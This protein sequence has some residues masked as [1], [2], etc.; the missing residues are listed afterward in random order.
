MAIVNSSTWSTRSLN[1]FNTYYPTPTQISPTWTSFLFDNSIQ[2]QGIYEFDIRFQETGKQV[3]NTGADD[4]AQF[5]IDGEYLG[6]FGASNNSK[7][8]TTTKYYDA[9]SVHRITIVR[10]DSGIKPTA[11]AA[12]WY[13]SIYDFVDVDDFSAAPPILYNTKTTILAWTVN[14]ARK[15]E[16]NQNIGDVTGLT[17]KSINT[18]LQSI[19]GTISPASKIY[20]LTAYGNAPSDILT[21]TVEVFAYNDTTPNKIDIPHFY[22]R[23]PNETITYTLPTITGIDAPITVS[24]NGS[25]LFAANG[26]S[27]FT[28]NITVNNNAVVQIRFVSLG[29][30]QD[31]QTLDNTIEYYV[32]IG[33][34]RKY[35]TVTTRA[36]ND[37][38]IF[39][40]GDIKNSVPYPVPP[41]NDENPPQ[42]LV[43]PDTVEPT[44]A[45]WEVELQYPNNVTLQSGVEIKTTYNDNTEIRVKPFGGSWGSWV[46]TEYLYDELI[47]TIPRILEGMNLSSLT[48]RDNGTISNSQPK[49]I[50][51]RSS[52]TLTA[53]NIVE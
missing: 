2:D 8:I 17:Q 38:E 31:P 26:V 45:Q 53:K 24:S 32:N 39:D 9:L 29:F 27:A 5:Y 40:F 6:Q 3:F 19:V 52:G 16:I 33:S 35:F 7:L 25:V 4:Y 14:N 20:T 46:K 12:R 15:I 48:T 51:T 11:V 18:G 43:S 41:G 13:S 44:A 28:T 34:L 21:R 10:S 1:I 23:E 50:N 22:N 49:S 37:N 42:Y 36:P 47:D 30:S